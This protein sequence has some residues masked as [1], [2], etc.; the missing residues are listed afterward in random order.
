VVRIRLQAEFLETIPSTLLLLQYWREPLV[1]K[2]LNSGGLLQ[3][4]ELLLSF[5]ATEKPQP[6][7]SYQTYHHGLQPSL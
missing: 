4:R 6:A 2:A 3:R 7:T 5:V 1:L